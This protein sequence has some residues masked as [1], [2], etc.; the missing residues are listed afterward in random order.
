MCFEVLE[1][2]LDEEVPRQA[3]A[4]LGHLC[5]PLDDLQRL[6][7]YGKNEPL[8]VAVAKLLALVQLAHAGRVL[9][10]A[11]LRRHIGIRLNAEKGDP[12]RR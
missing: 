8:L 9:V 12:A 1:V 2:L 10:R 3:C 5:R 6:E 4:L 7:G 11:V